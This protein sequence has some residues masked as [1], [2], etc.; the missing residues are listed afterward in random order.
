MTTIFPTLVWIIQLILLRVLPPILLSSTANKPQTIVFFRAIRKV[1]STI[2]KFWCALSVYVLRL[3]E[4]DS[5]EMYFRKF[6]IYFCS[7]TTEKR[8]NKNMHVTCLFFNCHFFC[9]RTVFCS[10]TYERLQMYEIHTFVAIHS[11]C[12]MF[13]KFAVADIVEHT[14][15]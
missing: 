2:S 6:L 10:S 4:S 15:P 7:G 12:Y 14:A 13:V 8:V 11:S 1:N 5:T 9:S 3:W